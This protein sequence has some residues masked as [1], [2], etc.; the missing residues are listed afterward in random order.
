MTAATGGLSLTAFG[1]KIVHPAL[2]T[3]SAR[4]TLTT[5]WANSRYMLGWAACWGGQLAGVSGLLGWEGILHAVSSYRGSRPPALAEWSLAAWQAEPYDWAFSHLQRKRE[6]ILVDVLQC[7]ILVTHPQQ[8]PHLCF[9]KQ[10][11]QLVTKYLESFC[12]SSLFLL[13]GF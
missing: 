5:L 10:G 4:I 11:L 9:S 7:H 2:V 13:E 8:G 6:I 1:K 12:I 3:T